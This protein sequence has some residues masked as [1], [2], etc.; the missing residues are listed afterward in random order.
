MFPAASEA[1]PL[2]LSLPGAFTPEECQSIAQILEEGVTS[3]A[4]LVNGQASSSIRKTDIHWIP[5]TSETDWIYQRLTRLIAQANRDVFRFNLS[6][7]D[8]DAQVARYQDGG[9]YDWHIDRGGRGAGRSR[10]LTI[11]VQLSPPTDYQGG[12]LQLNPDGRCVTAS[13]EQGTAVFF[14]AIMLHRV[15]PVIAGKRYSLVIWTHGPDFV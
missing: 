11:S 5:E 9:F 12:E 4:G 15:A 10:K 14:P 3:A 13:P 1:P 6:G 8:E 2:W 7:F